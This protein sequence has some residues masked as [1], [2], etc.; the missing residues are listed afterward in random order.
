VKQC[1]GKN[2]KLPVKRQPIKDNSTPPGKTTHKAEEVYK[3]EYVPL[4]ERS[5]WK[6]GI[7]EGIKRGKERGIEKGIEKNSK[8]TAKKMLNDGLP[9]ETISKY[10]GL[11]AE[12]IKKMSPTVH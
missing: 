12:E 7:R 11:P 6:K 1:P 8:E 9:L 10:T 3:M 5:V 2:W 4:W